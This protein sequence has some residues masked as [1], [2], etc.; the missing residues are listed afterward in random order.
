MLIVTV[1]ISYMM[2]RKDFAAAKE[3]K[4]FDKK[5]KELKEENKIKHKKLLIASLIT[6]ALVVIFFFLH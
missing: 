6:L 3:I 4:N 1:I 5:L 2:L